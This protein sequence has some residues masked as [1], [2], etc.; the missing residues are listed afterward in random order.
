MTKSTI[1]AIIFKNDK[2]TTKNAH[3]WLIKHG[4]HPIKRVDKTTHYLR[5]RISEPNKN[6]KYKLINIGRNGY[7]KAVIMY[8]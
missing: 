2:W 1:Q 6:S 3:S 5:Y 7:I 8:T 4:Y